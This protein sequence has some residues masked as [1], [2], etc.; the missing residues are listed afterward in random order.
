[1]IGEWALAIQEKLRITDIM[2]LQHS[3]ST[4]S[5]TTQKV[6]EK[7]RPRCQHKPWH[8]N[9]KICIRQVD[10]R[11]GHTKNIRPQAG[12]LIKFDT[13]RNLTRIKR[14]VKPG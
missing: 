12:S 6:S 7:W 1:M 13:T 2:M 3:F 11:F 5:F 14:W 10:Y 8:K 9:Q 4:I